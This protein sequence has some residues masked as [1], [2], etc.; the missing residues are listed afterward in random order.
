MKYSKPNGDGDL[1]W[2]DMRNMRN[3]IAHGYFTLD[4]GAV[5]DTVQID[6]PN[7]RRR[8]L[9]ICEQE[10]LPVLGSSR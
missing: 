8:L 7:L 2:M 1:P 3:R 6:M 5:W 4:M 9:A 10:G